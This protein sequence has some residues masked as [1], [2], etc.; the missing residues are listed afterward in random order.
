MTTREARGPNG[1]IRQVHSRRLPHADLGYSLLILS[2]RLAFFAERQE[3]Q[4]QAS[5][6]H[7]AS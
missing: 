7:C 3:R 4:A 5:S 1:R 2:M 6:P